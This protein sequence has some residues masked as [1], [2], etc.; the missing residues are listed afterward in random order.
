MAKKTL[1]ISLAKFVLWGMLEL[2]PVTTTIMTYFLIQPSETQFTIKQSRHLQRPCGEMM[3][4]IYSV[5]LHFQ[6]EDPM[7][8]CKSCNL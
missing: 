6:R 8:L 3:G 1:R 7:A 5:D 4:N 2:L